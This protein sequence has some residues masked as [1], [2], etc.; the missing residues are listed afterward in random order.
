[1]R[2][3]TIASSVVMALLL[4]AVCA[5][6]QTVQ[7][8]T[9]T[10][11]GDGTAAF[12]GDGNSGATAEISN[13][14]DVC[15]D[16]AGNVYF[17]DMGNHRVR[18][19]WASNGMVTT[20]AGAGSAIGDGIPALGSYLVPRNMCIDAA[21]DIFVVDSATNKI[22]RID[23]IT[24]IITTV[25]GAGVAGYSGDGGAATGATFSN[26]QGIAIDAANNI[27]LVD[28]GNNRV[29]MITAA[30]GIVSTIA[31][32]G[33][34]GYSGDGGPATAATISQATSICVS[35]TGDV[36]FADQS[37]PYAARIRKISG[38]A[39]STI[40]GLGTMGGS[41][42][43][44]PFM[45][46]TLGYVTGLCMD[47]HGD[48]YCNEV[49]CSCRRC[50]MVRDSVYEVAGN[51]GIESFSD[52]LNSPLSNM[53]NPYGLCVDGSENVYIADRLNNRVRKIIQ[54]SNAPSFAYGKGQLINICT[55]GT[56]A[57]I[58]KQMGITD[59]DFGQ[60]ET[61]TV[62]AGPSHGSVSG[63]PYS[64]LSTGTD[65]VT[66]PTGLSY[67]PVTGFVGTD[68]FKVQVSDGTYTGI[69]T[70]YIAVGTPAGTITSASFSVCM[71][72]PVS[73]S[74]NVPGGVWSTTTGNAAVSVFSGLVS[75]L[76]PGVDTLVYTVSNSCGTTSSYLP[77]TINNC[78][79]GINAAAGSQSLD[80]FPNPATSVL[81]IRWVNNE[82]N[83]A[84][85]ITDITGREIMRREITNSGISGSVQ[86]DIAGLPQGIY[87]VKL[88]DT[89]V[90]KFVKD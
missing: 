77:V 50:D 47:A 59:L 29:R 61:W 2:K 84:V 70:V 79:L 18:K 71:G 33:A 21:G 53:N 4:P 32:T 76:S 83:N 25:A 75:G 87:L 57:D 82:Q 72:T 62:L 58:N 6:A 40:A 78:S 80:V 46:T 31:G 66:F 90:K 56:S 17:T 24:N 49:S 88:N 55:A 89:S 19:I 36:Y 67:S 42:Y 81:N 86:V 22:R 45:S 28:C 23:A 52:C 73:F 44:S 74:E 65:S 39:I 43:N 26:I 3:F 54:L 10:L 12:N 5:H 51:F 9:V 35:T 63:F 34:A 60:T 85:T 14:Y 68:S 15:R 13:P 8:I 7:R 11:A 30:T 37:M 64:A 16:A 38:G 1:M 69:T 27:Y 41:I 20:I 48:M